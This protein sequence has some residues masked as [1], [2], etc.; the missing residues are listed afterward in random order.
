MADHQNYKIY[1][2]LCL[3]ESSQ[4]LSFSLVAISF[5]YLRQYCPELLEISAEKCRDLTE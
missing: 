4:I 5:A 2:L 3:C 1:T